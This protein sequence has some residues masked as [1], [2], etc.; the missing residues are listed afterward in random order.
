M[1]THAHKLGLSR[2]VSLP[3]TK[4]KQFDSYTDIKVIRLS[5]CLVAE[6]CKSDIMM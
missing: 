2:A 6:Y 3:N 1:Y 5:A 4:M